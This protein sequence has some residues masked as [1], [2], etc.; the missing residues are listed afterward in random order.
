MLTENVIKT[1]EIPSLA[2][3]QSLRIHAAPTS[4]QP[5]NPIHCR[6]WDAQVGAHANSSI[7]YS[8]AWAKV[9]AA[10]YGFTPICFVENS[11]GAAQSFLP[12]MEVRS[13]LTGRRGIGLPFTDYCGR[14]C[15]DADSFNKL[16]W[17]AVEYG[18][19]RGWKYL[20]YRGGREWLDGARPS[21]SFYGHT[22]NLDTDEDGLFAR[23]EGSVRQAIR[24][25]GK[26]GVTVTVS[27]DLE[28]MQTFY[29]LQCK[30]R[31]KHGLPPQP[32]AFFRNIHEHIL[33]HNLG[34]VVVAKSQERPIAASVYFQSGDRA[35]YKFGASDETFQHLRGP[36]L[37]MWEAIKWHV[38]NKAKTLHMG[39]TSLGNAGLR[40]FKLGWGAV[41]EQIEYVKYDLQRSQFIADKDESSGWHNQIFRRL[42]VGLSQLMGAMLYRHWA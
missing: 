5:V 14:L 30:T 33:S 7:F 3:S 42:P 35:V 37:V 40:R 31:K 18:K 15:P 19:A 36:N 11:G 32:F 34:V 38:H 2:V 16:F 28:A 1:T 10:T 13:W 39:R 9:L 8:V 12:L 21:L 41:E 4:A 25:A 23:L 24:K 26:S 27:R 20:E 6:N 29:S 22:L 17:R